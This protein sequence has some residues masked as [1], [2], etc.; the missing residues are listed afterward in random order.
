MMKM[1]FR[2]LRETFESLAGPGSEADNAQL[3]LWLNQA[4]NDLALEMGSAATSQYEAVEAGTPYPLPQDCLGVLS[5]DADYCL[6]DTGEICFAQGGYRQVVY[7]QAPTPFSG[8]DEEQCSTL[9]MVLHDLLPLFA[10]ARYWDTESEGDYEESNH[11][12]KWMEYYQQGKAL[13]RRMW[14]GYAPRIE[15]WQLE[16]EA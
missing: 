10:V 13:R 14:G 15:R 2:Q 5:A 9:P 6:T 12:S 3:A 1:N 4:Q 7:R 8:L 11:A 16:E